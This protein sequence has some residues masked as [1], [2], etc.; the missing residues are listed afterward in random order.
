MGKARPDQFIA[1]RIRECRIRCGLSQRQLSALIGV[2][3]QQ[4]H[5]YE[6]GINIVS[7]GRLYVIAHELDIP[8][9]SF[10]QGF[11]QDERRPLLRQRMLLDVVRNFGDIQNEKHQEAF[12]E[13]T[14]ALAGR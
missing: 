2:T 5:K 12:V 1:M 13:F 11:E 10:F 7:A 6:H 3:Y 4:V 8:L 9:E 14:R